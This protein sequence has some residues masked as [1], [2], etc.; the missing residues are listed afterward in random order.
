MFHYLLHHT[1]NSPPKLVTDWTIELYTVAWESTADSGEDA[2]Q[3]E[4]NARP[5]PRA[6]QDLRLALLSTV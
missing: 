1:Y 5:Q 2:V 3:P 4:L 6:C